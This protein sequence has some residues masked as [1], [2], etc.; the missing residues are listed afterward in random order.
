MPPPKVIE[1]ADPE[2]RAA[3][4]KLMGAHW[5]WSPAY[6]KD[7]VPVG[8]C[9]FRKSFSLRQVEFGQVHIAC[10]NQYELYVN[11]RL[12]G[13][14][15]DWRKMNVHDVVKFLLPGTNVVAIKATNTDAGAAGLVARVVIK[16]RGGTFE[17]H[18]T[19]GTWRTTVRPPMDWMQPR[20][21]DSE[22][23]YARVYGP[24]GGVLPWGDEIVIADEGSRFL[25][26]SE[27]AIERMVT[28]EQAG[29][30]IAMA[31]DA[32]GD[33][34]ASQEGGPLLLISR[35]QKAGSFDTVKPFCQE[36]RNIQG[37]LP[38]GSRVFAIGDGPAGGALYQ[39]IDKD[40]NGQSDELS[41]L[42]RF[43]GQVGEHGP[44]T[45]R[46]GPD[47]L[48]YI[49][50]GNFAQAAGPV[51]ARSP[52]S[53][54]YE[55]DLIKPRYEDPQGYAVGIKSPGGAVYRTDTS[56][57]LIE[58]VAAGF[59]NPYDFAF[60]DDGELFTNDAD[61]EWDIGAPWYRP[62]RIS[63]VP[64]G[65]EFGWRSGWAKWP[66][67]YLDSLP[68]TV[69]IGPG[70]PT[71]VVYYS[72][73]AF[74]PRLQNTLFVGDWAMGQIHAIKL[75]RSGATYRAKMSTF[76]KGRPLNVTGMDVGPEGALYFC[77]GGRGTD[78]GVYRVRWMGAPKTQSIQFAQGIEQALHQPQM[79]SDWARMRVAGVKRK[80]AESWQ[81]ELEKVIANKSAP[82]AD[83]SRAVD[84]MTQFGPAP[85]SSLLITLSQDSDPAMRVRAARLMGVRTEPEFVAPL[86]ALVADTDA[87]VRRVACESIAHRG[88]DVDVSLL[89]ALLSDSDRFVAFAAR[90]ALEKRP[91]LQWLEQV[92]MAQDP[93]AFLQGA[94][95][96][97][98]AQPSP[99]IAQ[100]ILD[101]C[102][103]MISGDVQEPG[104]RRGYISD[105]N[106]LDLLR[107][108]QLALDRGPVAAADVP[109]LGEKLLRE[110][111]TKHPMMNRELVKLLAY[112]QP[113][114][115]AHV[116]AKQL[117]SDV[118]DVEKLQIAAYAPRIKNGWETAD[119]L[120]MLSY[121]ERVRAIDG[122]HSIGGYIENFARDFFANLDNT[123]RRQL[124][125]AGEQYPTSALS[126]LA[127]LPSPIDPELLAE[128]RALDQRLEGMPGEP[129]A[130][131]RVGIVAVLGGSGD[132]PSLD[133]LRALYHKDPQRRAPVAMSLTQQ[134]DGENWPILVDSLRTVE[135]QPA[136]TILT[137]LAGVER[138]P[139]T[140]EP[141]RN[142]ILL[143]L[144]MRDEGGALA[145]RLLEKW[146][147][148][149]PYGPDTPFADQIAAWQTWYANTFPNEL[150]AELPR[151]SQPNKW[152]YEEL[153]SYLEGPEGTSGSPSR[154][155]K[156][157]QTAQCVS[158]H[159]FHGQGESLG[160]D[161]TTVAQRFQRKE[162]LESIVHPNQVV[163]DQYVSQIVIAGGKTYIGVAAKNP[164][165]SMTV[166]Q[167]DMQK[168]E[169][170]AEDIESVRPSKTSAMPEG[171]LN[172]LT[173]EQ[174]A[175]L[176]A[177]LMKSPEPSVAGRGTMGTR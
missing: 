148:Q 83:R 145:T 93:R 143:G 163:S 11:G 81:V 170:A 158:C 68:A 69:D 122:G 85:S 108:V 71:A 113:P 5:V 134:P 42:V 99:Q 1:Q 150:P 119:K 54:V 146:L 91:A 135:G 63:H 43:E 155:A 130:R 57:S 106:F 136:Q 177:F 147:G 51:D 132:A 110:Y 112:L 84:L 50:S 128:I 117:E 100:K 19:D 171:L 65:G 72:H 161:L 62:T 166:L 49:L 52:H 109:Q 33:I 160:P 20:I 115:A 75:E 47:G 152:S 80:L 102:G 15:N 86:A 67:Y 76:V 157:F 4:L 13:Q 48:L 114:Q 59:R 142:T 174:V 104:K 116:L 61:M 144:R 29:S 138:R 164:D 126:I 133:Y 53:T 137:A 107:V 77:T 95:G 24:L 89:V 26:D 21:R 151:E 105:P 125:A 88:D 90:R 96:L 46:L 6:V 25:I 175:D 9:Y 97:L 131:L 7:E 127:K 35:S 140:S 14:G 149:A 92:L 38:L 172:K 70:S 74:P 39:I 10:D 41:A 159:R 23:L 139:E 30:L 141:F 22:W 56:G 121:Y 78:G 27:F 101:R 40:A 103:A 111:P 3:F 73:T 165:G 123:E 2:T 64:L 167:A 98:V 118:P 28:N 16:E 124:L 129:V 34:L 31:F 87:W 168:V 58:R 153:A 8:D 79:T 44:H 156:V 169:L 154:G 37:I 17:S 66:D 176:F 94:T 32:N 60:N 173:L 36:L 12:A 55:G 162:I 120:T 45:V 82:P 18:S